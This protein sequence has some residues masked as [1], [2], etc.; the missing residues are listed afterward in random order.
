MFQIS[1]KFMFY[2]LRA[3]GVPAVEFTDHVVPKSHTEL[4]EATVCCSQNEAYINAF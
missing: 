1:R 2:Q 4:M 3:T